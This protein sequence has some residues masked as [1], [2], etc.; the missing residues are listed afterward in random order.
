VD[1]S[2]GLGVG[3]G[4]VWLFIFF[5]FFDRQPDC[6][7]LRRSL[8]LG[9]G[10]FLWNPLGHLRRAKGNSCLIPVL[11]LVLFSHAKLVEK[12]L[13]A[14]VLSLGQDIQAALRVTGSVYSN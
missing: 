5:V 9:G 3:L 7:F 1:V 8:D 10:L 6:R 13:P 11:N 4:P 12:H 2:A 14:A